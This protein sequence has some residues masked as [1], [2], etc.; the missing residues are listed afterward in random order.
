MYGV[1]SNVSVVHTFLPAPINCNPVVEFV[2]NY[3]YMFACVGVGVSS[4]NEKSQLTVG[5]ITGN[6]YYDVSTSGISQLSLGFAV[7][8][9]NM[10]YLI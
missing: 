1:V 8:V 5:P 4:M 2:N 9:V 3:S 10:K 6:L 7:S